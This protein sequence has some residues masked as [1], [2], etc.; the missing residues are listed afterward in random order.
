MTIRQVDSST[1]DQTHA[2][3]TNVLLLRRPGS[4]EIIAGAGFLVQLGLRQQVHSGLTT[5]FF[6]AFLTL[7]VW[8]VAL[9]RFSG[10]RMVF[11]LGLLAVACGLMLSRYSS[12]THQINTVDRTGQT[13]FLLG[14]LCGAGLIMWARSIFT[15][16]QIGFWFG[17]GAVMGAAAGFSANQGN[18]WK[19]VWAVPVAILVLSLG[20][21]KKRRREVLILG[22]LAVVSI[23][24]DSRSYFATF[25][26]TALIVV[27]QVRPRLRLKP[28]SWVWTAS[29]VAALAAATY[30]LGST[31]LVSGYLGQ[32]AQV[33]SIAQIRTSGSLI[34]GGRP[35]LAATIALMR[36]HP[37][38][39][40]V[41]VV[42]TPQDILVAKSGLNDINY[43]PNNGYVDRFMFGGHFEL[44][45]TFGDLWANWGIFG[46]ALAA[47]VAVLVVRAMSRAVASREASA[48]ML[49]L[50]IWTLWNL[51]FSPLAAAEPT[52]ML[53]L[54]TV[55]HARTFQF[56][57]ELNPVS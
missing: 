34:L 42:P 47:A 12:T 48:L 23:L 55:L 36:Y 37:L 56:K 17:A 41:G 9:R 53:T 45:S 11:L 6:L 46:L 54:G 28:A 32:N 29:L 2:P 30:Y 22:V 1:V 50:S 26:L 33:R 3:D 49:F 13:V 43:N 14:T 7:P 25:L 15:I 57:G 24:S 27:W 35:E 52:L 31:L 19:F 5:G 20:G 21:V 10:A 38:G 8:V 40:G 39:F 4:L 18:A 51:L 44:H 16:P